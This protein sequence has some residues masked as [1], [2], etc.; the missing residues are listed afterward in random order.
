MKLADRR[1][2]LRSAFGTLAASICTR[3]APAFESPT[4]GYLEVIASSLE[5]ARAAYKGGAARLEVAVRLQQGGLT[6]PLDL[7]RQIVDDVPI[8]VRVML[9][10]GEGVQLQGP[11]ELKLLSKKAEAIARMNVDGIVFGFVKGGQIDVD[12]MRQIASVAPST[13]FTVHNAIEMTDDPLRALEAVRALP[14]VDRVLVYGGKGTLSNRIGRLKAYMR[15]WEGGGDRHVLVNG[16]SLQ[17]FT[18]VRHE[19]GAAEF[20]VSEQV[21]VPEEPYPAGR[22][23]V[24]KVRNAV[25]LLLGR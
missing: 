8:L 17:E 10:E 6:P 11:G 7:I 18:V 15:V 22:I 3:A 13:H 1:Y 16:F 21:R 20:H 24:V 12:T 5:D 2:F 23:N 25:E 14:G 9:R 4:R 19:T